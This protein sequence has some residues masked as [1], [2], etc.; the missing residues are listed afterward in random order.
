MH[1]PTFSPQWHKFDS[2]FSVMEESCIS[3]E[4]K[5]IISLEIHW[6]KWRPVQNCLS[7]AFSQNILW[8]TGWFLLYLAY[9]LASSYCNLQ[10]SLL[11][12]QELLNRLPRSSFSTVI[13]RL[14]RNTRHALLLQKR[15][16]VASKSASVM[17]L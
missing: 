6:R 16:D 17:N 2:E 7:T 5:E 13:P 15:K 3:S 12:R 4:T 8:K 9:F 14:S 10:L 1:E 11:I